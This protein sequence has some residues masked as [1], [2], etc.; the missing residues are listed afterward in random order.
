MP[1]YSLNY[2]IINYIHFLR[3]SVS[4]FLFVKGVAAVCSG[5]GRGLPVPSEECLH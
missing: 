1:H 4:V 3:K 2:Y 5:S